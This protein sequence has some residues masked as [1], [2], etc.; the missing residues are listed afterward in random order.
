M[1]D[2]SESMGRVAAAKSYESRA[3]VADALIGRFD[4]DVET[5]YGS[6]TDLQSQ[7]GLGAPLAV[8]T[9]AYDTGSSDLSVVVF[10]FVGRKH[11]AYFLVEGSRGLG[12]SCSQRTE[13]AILSRIDQDV[14]RIS[15]DAVLFLQRSISFAKFRWDFVF[16]SRK[17]HEYA[18]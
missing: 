5:G 11:G 8:A 9:H 7:T 15:R 10:F 13:D 4:D 12:S 1:I 18:S 6:G 3:R 16:A 2:D 14:G 17:I